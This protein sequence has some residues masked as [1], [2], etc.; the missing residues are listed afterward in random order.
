[1]HAAD[2]MKAAAEQM[3]DVG[4]DTRDGASRTAEGAA[5]SSQNLAALASAV[6]EMSSSIDEITRRVFQIAQLVHPAFEDAATTDAKMSDVAQTTDRISHVVVELITA[7]ASQT[8]LLALNATTEAARAGDAGKGFAVVAG[9]VKT[10]AAQTSKATGEI[11]RQIAGVR[12][13]TE[14]AVAAMR[15]TSEAIARV[16]QVAAADATAV[17]PFATREIAPNVN[18]MS[19]ATDVAAGAMRAVSLNMEKADNVSHIV[20]DAAAQIGRAS[21]TLHGEIEHFPRAMASIEDAD[22]GDASG[23]PV[24]ARA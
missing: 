1:M 2:G 16:D 10:L 23:F 11:G 15:A 24:A 13:A 6:G 5:A 22:A 17:Q 4:A 9:E 21:Q 12:G 8:N 18:N 20:L 3:R 7:I 14:Q 19:R